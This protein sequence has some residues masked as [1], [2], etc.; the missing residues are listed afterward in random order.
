[1]AL[2]F[3]KPS[4]PSSLQQQW[5]KAWR[6]YGTL[7]KD[8]ALAGSSFLLDLAL[9]ALFLHLTSH[10]FSSV[11]FARLLSSLYN[12]L[13]NRF[14]VFKGQHTH[15]LHK[16]VLGYVALAIAMMLA[17]ASAVQWLVDAWA[18]PPVLTKAGVDILLYI[19]SFLI[20][21]TWLFRLHP[22]NK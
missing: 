6:R 5:H 11:V 16:Q 18:W 12:F 20:R 14:F 3:M 7:F 19:A 8:L 21:S 17:S 13:G 1:M 10:V 9:F 22:H 15:A 4:P 2:R